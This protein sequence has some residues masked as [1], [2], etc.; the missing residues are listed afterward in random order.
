[1]FS[2]RDPFWD[3]CAWHRSIQL[4]PLQNVFNARFECLVLTWILHETH[5][6]NCHVFTDA[7]LYVTSRINNILE[8]MKN[9]KIYTIVYSTLIDFRFNIFFRNCNN[10][11][12]IL[13]VTDSKVKLILKFW[14]KL[15]KNKYFACPLISIEIHA[16]YRF[17]VKHE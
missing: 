4:R 2:Q 17:R 15:F 10:N 13:C 14:L 7:Y 12:S 3:V 16:L 11:K 9:V 1:M 6:F 5:L 8:F